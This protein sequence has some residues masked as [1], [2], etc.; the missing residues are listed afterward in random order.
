MT[1][2]LLFCS[3]N[4]CAL[5]FV[6]FFLFYTCNFIQF[7]IINFGKNNLYI[8][9]NYLTNESVLSSKLVLLG[10]ELPGFGRIAQNQIYL[11]TD[12]Q[13]SEVMS[14]TVQIMIQL[15]KDYTML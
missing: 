3:E 1:Y 5:W 11:L 14:V 10:V 9:K 15:K 12:F 6:S 7:A 8:L 13:V 4:I 2:S